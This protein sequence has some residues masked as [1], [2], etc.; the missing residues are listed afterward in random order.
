MNEDWER[1]NSAENEG[2]LAFLIIKDGDCGKCHEER[3]R[4][5]GRGRRAVWM[6]GVNHGLDGRMEDWNIIFI[7]SS[8]RMA[9][10][11]YSFWREEMSIVSG[12]KSSILLLLMSMRNTRELSAHPSSDVAENYTSTLRHC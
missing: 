2:I 10:F 5:G 11:S 6:N 12:V 4:K 3:G 9:V 1:H 7:L 8:L